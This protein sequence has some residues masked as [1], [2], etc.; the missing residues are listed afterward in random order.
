MGPEGWEHVQ[1]VLALQ[2]DPGQSGSVLAPALQLLEQALPQARIICKTWSVMPP[3]PLKQG[4]YDAV[5]IFTGITQ[6]P[7]P[8]AYACY[9]A[10]I[11]LRLGQSREFGGGVLSHWV[12]SDPEIT[13]PA[14][15]HLLMLQAAGF[16]AASVGI[17]TAV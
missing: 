3:L 6:S 4:G 8:L 15:W 16:R 5:V 17:R 12:K 1:R 2:A 11:P 10:G 13:D 7:Y 9:L 14:V